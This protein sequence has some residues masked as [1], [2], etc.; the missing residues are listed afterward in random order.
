MGLSRPIGAV[1]SPM[2]VGLKQAK[3]LPQASS[4]CGA[5]REVCPI[6]IDIPRML[7]DLRKKTAESPD[8]NLRRHP[9]LNA[10]WLVCSQV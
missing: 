7:L 5:C 9:N 8:R 2:L 4:L 3:E 6:K 1:V 10:S